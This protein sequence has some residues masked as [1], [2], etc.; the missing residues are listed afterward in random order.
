M[1]D[2]SQEVTSSAIPAFQYAFGVPTVTGR[3]KV[4]CEDFV[5][6]EELGFELDGE[7][8]HVCL[9]IE[10]RDLNTADVAKTLQKFAGINP[11]GIGYCGLKDRRAITRQWFSVHCGVHQMPDWTQLESE[12]LRVIECKRHRKKLRVGAH[13]ANYF[14]INIRELSCDPVELEERLRKI[15]SNGFP[16]YFGEQRFGYNG[17][18]INAAHAMFE[19]LQRRRSRKF[20]ARGKDSFLL[21]ASRALLFNK[22]LSERIQGAY[23][24]QALEGDVL[25]LDGRNSVFN[26]ALDD[27]L[28]SRVAAGELHPTGPLHGVGGMQPDGRALEIESATLATEP[29]LVEG[30][31][32]ISMAAA[33]RALRALA[34]D[35]SW[36]IN[37]AELRLEFGLRRGSYA[38]SLI[39]EIVQATTR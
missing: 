13:R 32:G 14:S 29:H 10:K 3:L 15:Q 34:I 17:S 38:T 23:W 1:S 11:T 24:N 35:F 31:E 6:H 5:V 9:H 39:R 28:R 7:G 36:Q 8:E 16:N 26:Q 37:S 18:N 2:V 22:V 30:L 33:R 4:E 27:S 21:S 19:R 20:K 25:Q 12:Q